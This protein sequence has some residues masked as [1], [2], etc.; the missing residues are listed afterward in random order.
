VN[1]YSVKARNLVCD[2][3]GK[4]TIWFIKEMYLLWYINDGTFGVNY[5][6]VFS[7]WIA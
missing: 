6:D 7:D 3:S 2:N 1:V 5:N 4:S